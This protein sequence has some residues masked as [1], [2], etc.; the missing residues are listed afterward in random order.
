MVF[1]IFFLTPKSP[2]PYPPVEVIRQKES[3][4]YKEIKLNQLIDKIEYEFKKDS[5]EKKYIKQN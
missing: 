1:G 2:R 4:V 3:I 5:I